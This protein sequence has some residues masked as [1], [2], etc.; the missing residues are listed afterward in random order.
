MKLFIF[1]KNHNMSLGSLAE[2]LE[3]GL[4]DLD[5]TETP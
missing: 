4:W 2:E 1:T 3:E 5:G